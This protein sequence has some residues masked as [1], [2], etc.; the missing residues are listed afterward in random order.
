MTIALTDRRR[1]LQGAAATA[2]LTIGFHWTGLP[3]PAAAADDVLAPNAFVRVAPDNSVTVIIKHVELGQGTY[4]GLATIVAEE[5]DADWSQVRA[6]SAPADATRYNNLL[7]GPIQGTGGST[8]VAN[9]W[10]Q[11]RTAGATARA[12]LV[13]AA[14]NEWNVPASAIKVDRGVV[15]HAASGRSANFGALAGKAAALPVPANISLKN[16]SDFRLIGQYV[17]RL[18]T[19]AKTNGSAQFALD[20][21]LPDMLTA[22]IARP[23]LFG[24]TVRSLDATSA[25]A[26]AGVTDV[27]QVPAGVAVAGKSFWAAKQGRDALKIEWDDSA[28]EKRS[29]RMPSGR[30]PSWPAASITGSQRLSDS[31]SPLRT[32]TQAAQCAAR[33]RVRM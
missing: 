4:T 2:G 29:D 16:P 19:P 24:A 15:R 27:V 32:A 18:D 31:R 9:S 26:I 28:A 17:P 20:V 11:L 22:V 33:G 6:E 10:D 1:F 30:G 21:V 25:K 23:P 12:M 7:L 3:R 8:A 14:A 13:A 5:L